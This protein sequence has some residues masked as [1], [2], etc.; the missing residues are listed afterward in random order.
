MAGLHRQVLT[1]FNRLGKV[2]GQLNCFGDISTRSLQR[3]QTFKILSCDFHSGG[4][5][6]SDALECLRLD[7]KTTDFT[8]PGIGR[9]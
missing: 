9:T 4:T 6:D 3:I 7:S 5:P 2:V 8:S 1:S